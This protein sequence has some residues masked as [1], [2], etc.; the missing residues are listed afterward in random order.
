LPV[1]AMRLRWECSIAMVPVFI[2]EKEPKRR[3]S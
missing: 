2:A 1:F 3:R